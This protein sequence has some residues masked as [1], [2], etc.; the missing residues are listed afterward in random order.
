MDSLRLGK[1]PAIHCGPA[2]VWQPLVP[3]KENA[4]NPCFIALLFFLVAAFFGTLFGLALWRLRKQPPYGSMAPKST[5]LR[6]WVRLNAVLL[7]ALLYAYA[8]ALVSIHER[9][10]DAK[11]AAFGAQTLVILLLALPLHF[12][13]TTRSPMPHDSLI[14]YWLV[15]TLVQMVLLYQDYATEWVLLRSENAVALEV[16]LVVNSVALVYLESSRSQWKPS[17]ELTLHYKTTEALAD[18]LQRPTFFERITFTWVNDLIMTAYNNGTI[19][20]TDIPQSPETGYATSAERATARFDKFWKKQARG[21][22]KLAKTLVFAFGPAT[23]IA[24]AYE[25]AEGLLDFVQPQLLRLFIVFFNERLAS[26]SEPLIR[27]ISIAFLMFALTILKTSLFNRYVLKMTDASLGTRGALTSVIYRKSI[28]LSSESKAE[29]SPGDI[30]NLMSVDVNRVLDLCQNLNTI[31]VAPVQ[32]VLCIMSLWGLFGPSTLAGLA[33]ILLVIPLNTYIFRVLKRLNKTQMKI[34]D[35]RSRFTNEILTSIRSLK[36]YAWE[37][38]MLAKLLDIRNN[39]ELRNVMKIRAINQVGMLLLFTMPFLVSFATF[40]TFA[41]TQ[42]TPLTADIIFP[43]LALLNILSYPIMAIPN[44]MT[45]FLEASI[46]VGRIN[47]FLAVSEANESF[48]RRLPALDKPGAETVRVE[49]CSFAWSRVKTVSEVSEDTEFVL[50]NAFTLRDISLS[51]RNGELLSVVGRVGAGKSS[52]LAALVGQLDTIG[53][54]GVSRVSIAGTIAYCAQTP[55]I[56]NASVRENIVFGHRFDSAYYELTIEAC[57]LAQD[58][59]ILPDGDETQVGEKG[60]SLSG[61]QKARLSLARAVYARADVYLLDDILSAV[62]SHVGKQITERVLS[63]NGVLGGKSIILATN[64]IQVLKHS[65]AIYLLE[66]G[67]VTESGDYE[68]ANDRLRSPKLHALIEEFGRDGEGT[69]ST[70]ASA[71]GL[72]SGLELALVE[73]SSDNGASSETGALKDVFS[74]TEAPKDVS[75]EPEALKGLPTEAEAFEDLPLVARRASIETFNWDPIAK[76]LPNL[77]TARTTETSAQGKVKKAVYYRY[78]KACSV[79]GIV[80]WVVFMVTGMCAYV[81]A[82]YWLKH[83]AEKNSETGSN[84]DALRYIAVYAA[85]GLTSSLFSFVRSLLIWLY[86]AING[87]RYV[88]DLMAR[89]ILRAPMSFFERTP[90]GRIMNRFTNDVSKL[91][92]TLPRVFRMFFTRLGDTAVT[93]AV[94]GVAMPKFLV[95]VAGLVVVYYYYQNFFVSISRELKRLVSVA[96]SPIY[97]HLQELLN[98]VDTIAAYNQ[99]ARFRFINTANVNFYSQSLVMTRSTNRWLAVRLQF[100]GSLVIWSTAMLL[101]YS[102]TTEKPL[103]GAMVGFL[104]SYALTVTN[105]LSFLIRNSAEVESNIVAAERCLEYCDLEVEE[106][107]SAVFAKP[108][109]AWPQ[110]GDITFNSYSTRYREN[111]DLVLKDVSLDIKAGE[112]I[113]VVGRTG[114]GKSSLALALFRIIPPAS[115]NIVIDGYNTVN[116]QLY[117]LRRNLSIIPQDSQLFEGLIRQN[118]DPFDYYKDHELWRVLELAH[119]KAFILGLESDSDD[120]LMCKVSAGGS[121]FSSGQRQLMCLARALL[122]PSRILVLDEATAAVDVQTDKIIQE[123]IRSELKDKTIITIAHRLDTVMDSD[124][125]LVLEEGAV[126]EFDSPQKLLEDENSM[127]SHFC[128]QGGYA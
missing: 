85:F 128:K 82:D 65:D 31:V 80:V 101:V 33:V 70:I 112:K 117:D 111:L 84:K 86:L 72:K 45:S 27:G 24:L 64:S 54:E 100:I 98:G 63:K 29:K 96:R 20:H 88:H 2:A 58:L 109:V 90:V 68:T 66:D 34:K 37:E 21:G 26:S 113:G 81:F 25:L 118:L 102:L 28:R 75:S 73:D 12:Q 99:E 9:F 127:F 3:T 19:A 119:L 47:K 30:V 32:L 13:E 43:G 106:D 1:Y 53:N 38:P 89:R 114:A 77:R 93:F 122:S 97:A 42:D 83:W 74:E 110:K 14:C 52:L 49:K 123:T 92:D 61:G 39:K 78:A 126:R 76:A 41:L 18:E 107:E 8:T 71:V 23:L 57:Q 56:M 115:G 79:P 35:E 40:G 36:L 60:I 44:V 120:K 103:G 11:L 95:V 46:S 125:I 15:L 87:S 7:Q 121:N 16:L 55:W 94:I 59:E 5:G 124:R 108:P 17:H 4:F 50:Q 91:D 67:K 104:M 105:S 22:H 51:A 62:D 6:H 10:A 116:L 69:E 48:A